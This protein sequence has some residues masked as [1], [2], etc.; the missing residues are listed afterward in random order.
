M[1]EYNPK[2]GDSYLCTTDRYYIDRI[3]TIVCVTEHRVYWD[4]EHRTS[5]NRY[6]SGDITIKYYDAIDRQYFERFARNCRLH[7]GEKV[8]PSWEL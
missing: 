7:K 3:L 2:V 1:P 6:T 4:L 5:T 8:E